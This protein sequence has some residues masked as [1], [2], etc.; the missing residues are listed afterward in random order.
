MKKTFKYYSIIWAVLFI[1]FQVIAFVPAGWLGLEKYTASF[2]IGYA[3]ILLSFAGQL[4]CAYFALKENNIKKIFYNISLVTTSYTGLIL[5]FVFG[6]LCMMISMLP[7][8]VG[9]VLCSVLLAFNVIAVLKAAAAIE[10][11]SA[12]DDKV[13]AKTSFIKALTADAEGLISRAK[14]E[15]VKAEC[16]KVY[17]AVR[18]SDPMSDEALSAIE[19]EITIQFAKLTEA[20]VEGNEILTVETAD[21]LAVILADRNNKCKLLK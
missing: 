4:L 18:Y 1:L 17:E 16:K 6:G 14:S 13:K 7:Y 3:F 20:V 11:V 9:I 2:W 10:L 5:S 19:D 21:E 12:V 15:T 8:W